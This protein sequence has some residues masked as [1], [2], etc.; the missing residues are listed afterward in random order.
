MSLK[1]LPGIG[2]LI[3]SI[4]YPVIGSVRTRI[5]EKGAGLGTKIYTR[6]GF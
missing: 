1:F 6:A 3:V 2:C 5:Y 4:E